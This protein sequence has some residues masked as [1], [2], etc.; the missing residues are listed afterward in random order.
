MVASLNPAP[1][2]GPGP[3]Q[4]GLDAAVRAIALLA[5]LDDVLQV[6]VD[7]VRPIVRAHYAALGIVDGE[8]RIERFITSGMAAEERR[9]IGALPEGH[10][11]LGLIIREN[12]S[13][14][15][16]DLNVDPRRY[17]FPPH[18]P[19]MSSFLGVPIT[20]R[21][22]TIGRLYLTN[23]IGAEEFSLADEAL[24]ETFALH[25]GIAMDNARLHDELQRLA[26]VDERERISKDL[27]DGIIQNLYAVGLSLEVVPDLIDDDRTE[28]AARIEGAID[29][30]HM[31]IQDIRN[32]IF[33]LRPGLLEGASLVAGLAAIVGEYRTH[34]PIDLELH[35]EE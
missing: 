22:S 27:H 32:F 14:R 2:D 6:I 21:G 5:P 18:H 30:I 35:I 9:R 20:V 12:R 31:S 10:G 25:A 13:F 23:K 16:R 33:G 1:T 34:S 29:S 7:Q 8:G 17:G 15:I 4:A 28:A 3:V 19:P 11:L 24:V 26:I